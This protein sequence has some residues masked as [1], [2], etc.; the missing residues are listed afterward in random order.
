MKRNKE[1]KRKR[2][3]DDTRRLSMPPN[4]ASKSEFASPIQRNLPDF[5]FSRRAHQAAFWMLLN[6]VIHSDR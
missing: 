4:P 5:D 1:W 3:L 2:R 6:T